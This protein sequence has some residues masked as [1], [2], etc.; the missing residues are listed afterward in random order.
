MIFKR[1]LLKK[2]LIK[3]EKQ[4]AGRPFKWGPDEKFNKT[5]RLS[6][7]QQ[8][9]IYENHP[10]LQAWFESY[11]LKFEKDIEKKEAMKLNL[12]A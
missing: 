11:F 7:R 10:S 5:F 6:Q 3:K 2:K 9:L 8:D 1:K 4:K 12:I